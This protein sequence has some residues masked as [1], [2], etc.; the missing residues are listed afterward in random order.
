MGEKISLPKLFYL[1]IFTVLAGAAGT[2]FFFRAKP[3][4]KPPT[5]G[6]VTNF[7]ECL[8]A[9]YF[10]INSQPRQC[11]TPDGQVFIEGE[12]QG[13]A[14]E[15][16]PVKTYTDPDQ[17]IEIQK[18]EKFQ[19]D[20]DSNPTTGYRWDFETETDLLFLTRQNFESKS[21]LM[22]AS[23]IEIFEFSASASGKTTIKFFYH[24]PWEEGSIKENTFQVKVF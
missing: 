13:E 6:K 8:Q 20:L 23:G 21:D 19:I 1:A 11:K 3:Q 15:P 14:A 10:L 4:A 2:W 18:G 9:D 17:V 7:G 16:E 24:R 22:G 12:R 5:K